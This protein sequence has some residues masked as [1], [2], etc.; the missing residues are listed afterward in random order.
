MAEHERN[1]S[2]LEVPRHI[3]VIMDGNGRWA[4]EQGLPRL[5]GH[6]AGAKTVRMLVEEARKRGV[7]YLTLFAFSSENWK[8]P[9]D[10]VSGLMKLF[11]KYLESELDTLLKNDVRLRAI[12]NRELLPQRVRDILEEREEATRSLQA[13]DLV[14]AVSYGGRDEIVHAAREHARRV[15]A[16]EISVEDISEEGFSHAFYCPDLPD[17]DLLIRTSNEHRISNFLLWQLAYSEIMVVP[18]YWPDFS[19]ESFERCLESYQVRERRFGLTGEQLQ[20][21]GVR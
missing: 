11:E 8:R 15:L 1:S 14:L 13:M 3:A 12:G 5:E 18:E 17:V 7:R 4:K 6:R 19:K 20:S 21:V 16:G 2:S 9:A 10:E